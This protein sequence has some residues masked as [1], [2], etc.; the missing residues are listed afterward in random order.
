MESSIINYSYS[1]IG[2]NTGINWEKII[3]IIIALLSLIIAYKTY[4]IAMDAVDNWQKQVKYENITS[5]KKEL[6][7]VIVDYFYTLDIYAQNID[8][9]KQST[10]NE[11]LTI[12]SIDTQKN[13]NMYLYFSEADKKQFDELKNELDKYKESVLNLKFKH[14]SFSDKDNSDYNYKQTLQ[15]DITNIETEIKSIKQSCEEK[16]NNINLLLKKE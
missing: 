13:I 9:E 5:I 14:E 1:I 6:I 12:K 3:S 10:I 15:N 2:N 4:K 11:E 16:I 7:K 8:A